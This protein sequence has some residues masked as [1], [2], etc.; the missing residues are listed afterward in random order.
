[1]TSLT[2]VGAFKKEAPPG[3]ATKDYGFLVSSFSGALDFSDT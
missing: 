2:A 1:M 3:G